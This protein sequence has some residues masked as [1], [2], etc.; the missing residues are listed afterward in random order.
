MTD[1]CDESMPDSLYLY[2]SSDIVE[3]E[4]LVKRLWRVTTDRQKPEIPSNMRGIAQLLEPGALMC[5]SPNCLWCGGLVPKVFQNKSLVKELEE[6]QDNPKEGYQSPVEILGNT[7]CTVM[8]IPLTL[9]KTVWQSLLNQRKDS[10]RGP[11]VYL[12]FPQLYIKKSCMCIQ[13]QAETR[14]FTS[15]D[16]DDVKKKI[17]DSNQ[18]V[19]KLFSALTL[20]LGKTMPSDPTQGERAVDDSKQGETRVSG[21]STEQKVEEETSMLSSFLNFVLPSW[22]SKLFI[23]ED[24]KQESKEEPEKGATSGFELDDFCVTAFTF[25]LTMGTSGNIQHELV[26]SSA[27]T[28]AGYTSSRVQL[29]QE[30]QYELT[31]SIF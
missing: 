15:D 25:K 3:G 19:G 16:I 5:G 14:L 30:G 1:F 31:G 27:V 13:N 8:K 10:D 29:S 28:M 7:L 4:G 21:D 22:M 2:I 24:N 23:R 9:D 26:F 6:R 12:Y 20:A 18:S 17:S 11:S